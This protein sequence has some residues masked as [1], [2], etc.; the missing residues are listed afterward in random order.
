M[1]ATEPADGNG[2]LERKVAVVTGGANGIG[3]A[4]A[5]RLAGEGADVA[6]LDL[7]AGTAATA[8]AG[9]AAATGA[10]VISHGLDL[11]DHDAV[12]AAFDAAREELGEIDILLNNVG[13]TAREN[14]SEF[15]NSKPE[16]WDFVI[17][18]SLMTTLK[19]THQ[20][21]ARMRERRSGKIICIASDTVARGDAGMADY[22]AA[23]SGV[24]G[25]VR[26]LARELA[27]F[28]VNVNAVCPG[29]TLTRGPR[30][31]SSEFIA[32]TIERIPMG[33]ACRPEDVAAAVAFLASGDARLITGQALYVNGGRVFH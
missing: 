1:S 17:G 20:V 25:F 6:I 28:G 26:S 21:A 14:A 10:R 18:V 13:Q 16:T 32:R 2:R 9:I 29:L 23:K 30:K 3:R 22:V 11:T 12:V 31:L 33:E 27:P 15:W 8:A 5:A 7:E 19:A 4:C 24:I